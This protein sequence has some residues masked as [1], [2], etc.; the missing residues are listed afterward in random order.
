MKKNSTLLTKNEE[1]IK[2]SLKKQ[3]SVRANAEKQLSLDEFIDVEHISK[4]KPHEIISVIHELHVHQIE[5]EMQNNELTRVSNQ[6]EETKSKYF[7]LYEFAPVG[8]VVLSEKGIIIETN[9]TFCTLL[10]TQRNKLLRNGFSRFIK[11][12]S[13]NEYFSKLK[14]SIN[15]LVPVEMEAQMMRS[16]GFSFWGH[17]EI[18]AI[19]D[20][21]PMTFKIVLI[22]ISERVKKEEEIQYISYH[23]PLT[24]LYN[25]RFYEQELVRLDTARNYPLTIL[26]G[27]VN[28]LKLIN[29][30]FGHLHGDK[31]LIEAAQVIKKCCRADEIIARL[32]G[33]EFVVIL[34]NTQMLE[35]NII[36]ERIKKMI[37]DLNKKGSLISISFGTSSKTRQGESMESV[38]KSAED[39]MYTNK[40]FEHTSSKSNMIN[41][42]MN[43]LYEKNPREIEHSRRVSDLCYRI[44]QEMNLNTIENNQVR[45]AG[46]MH[47]IGKVG[48]DESILNSNTSLTNQEFELLKKHSEMGYRILVSVSEFSQVGLI[49]L[50]HHERWDGTGYPRKLKNKEIPLLARIVSLAD[51]FDAMTNE[52]TYK[53]VL[54]HAEAMI[55]VEKCSGAQ[56]D[57]AVV[58]VFKRMN[59]Q[60][61]LFHS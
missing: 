29:D 2:T 23:D 16:D 58:A 43:T 20:V 57:P 4:M 40:L 44:G 27:D 42:I 45:L 54:S 41:L 55:E 5:L 21:E 36:I 7:D 46:L 49:V 39:Q 13:Q 38:F 14:D 53:K 28:G 25:R 1:T 61:S 31:I 59:E 6:L 26:M 22:D 17:L 37:E 11:K 8:Y 19:K 52:R 34:P 24:G 33:D 56:F 9:L 51:S 48:I 18:S 10:L 15:A 35:V 12:E 3:E 50:C 60:G 47:D 32:G 30:S